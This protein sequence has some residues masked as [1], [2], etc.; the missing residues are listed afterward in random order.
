MAGHSGSKRV[1]YA[2]LA[3]NVA[4]ALTK[5]AAAFFTGSSAMLSE[6]VHSLVD[7]G[8]GALLL[9][10]MR[11]AAR[12]PDRT[13]PL[14]HGREL[15]FWSFIV[16]LLVFALGAG[17]SFYEGVI[18]IMAPE[19]V[20]NAKVNYIVLGLSFLF[21]G[22]SWLVALK[23]FRQQK[24]KQGWF[25]AVRRSKDPSVYTVLFEDSAALLGLVVAFAGILTSELLAIPELD[26][27]GS[28]GIAVILGATAIFLARESKGLLLGEPASP[29]VERKVLVIADHDPAVQRANG[30][31]SVHIGP[32]EIVA[33]LSIEF[34]DHLTAPEIEA[35][36]ERLEARLKSD[37]PEI[38]R[39]FVKPQ[40]TGTWE[41][42]RKPIAGAFEED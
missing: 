5:F 28:I 16:A 13:H 7:T 37:M 3:G 41:R 33:G 19:P 15:Y 31:L 24:G 6:G 38:T 25:Q 40:A 18:H 22:S 20:V 30:I 34:E 42:R 4:I 8:N 36:V 32:Q 14:G 12:P 2:A 21:E 1:I 39:L 29:E 17:V 26:G 9:Y 27:A 11:R 23:E 35:C 10:G